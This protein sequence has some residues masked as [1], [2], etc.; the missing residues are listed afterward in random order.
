[1]P[2]VWTKAVPRER[3]DW[4]VIKDQI[5]LTAVATSLL[6]EPPGRGGR[7]LWWVCPLHDDRNPSFNVDPARSRWKC[8]G[9]GEYGD[10]ATLAMKVNGLTFPEAV[11]L[12]AGLCGLGPS[13]GTVRPTIRP[14]TVQAATRPVEKPSG[15]PHAD[16]VVLVSE[17]AQRLWTPEGAEAVAYLR[18]RGLDDETIRRARLGYVDTV[19]FQMKNG[20]NWSS[21]PGI[22]IPWFHG[23]RLASINVRRLDG[24]TWMKYKEAFRDRRRVYP[25]LAAIRAGR[26]LVIVEGEFDCLLLAQELGDVACVITLGSASSRLD[27]DFLGVAL[28]ASP[29]FTAHD[30]DKAGDKAA[31]LWPSRGRRVRPPEGCKDWT[32]VHATGRHRVRYL[33]GKRLPMSASWEELA[34]ARWGPALAGHEADDADEY[35]REERAALRDGRT[36]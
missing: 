1:M 18:G 33:W 19:R 36:H 25:S 16:A 5:D 4:H 29:W 22:A 15:L 30:A 11:R 28:S 35:A 20:E 31:A 26:P 10:A 27:A 32:D 2:S 8:F 17:A 24:V 9:C 12:V 23:D 21:V 14:P 7:G 13:L 34:S 6:G 3:L